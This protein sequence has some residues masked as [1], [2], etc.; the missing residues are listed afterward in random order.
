M[1][2]GN[3]IQPEDESTEMYNQ[4]PGF[5]NIDEKVFIPSVGPEG[6]WVPNFTLSPSSELIGKAVKVGNDPTGVSMDEFDIMGN[7]RDDNPDIGAF[8]FSTDT[9]PP[10]GSFVNTKIKIFLEG[11]YRDGSMLPVL[12]DAIVIP[13]SQPYSAEPWN[14]SGSEQLSE[15]PDGFVDWVL[16]ELRKADQTIAA[17]RAAVLL[18]NGSVVDIDGSE[19]VKFDNLDAGNYYITVRHRNHLSVMSSEMVALSEN[20]GLYDFTASE[21]SA[22]GEN[23]LK[24]LGGGVFAL[25]SG[26]GNSDGVVNVLDYGEIANNIYKAGYYRGDVN[27]DSVVNDADYNSTNLNLF[28]ASYVPDNDPEKG[29]AQK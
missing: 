4:D 15:L 20:S 1:I 21:E 6:V 28:N 16:I 22:Y 7:R 2:R 14:Y 23:P 19:G 25:F 12:N 8:E 29:S 27:M 13:K 18:S 17:S 5:Q 9:P 10:P 11:S 26:D 24:N 3:R